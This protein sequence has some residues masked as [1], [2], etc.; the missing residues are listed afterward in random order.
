MSTLLLRFAAPL[1]AWGTDSKFEVRRTDRN[2]SKSGVI[3]LLGAALGIPRDG[4]F[5]ALRRLKMGVRVDR[6]GVLL[7]D[8][9]TAHA[10]EGKAS[11]ITHRYYLSDAI[12]LVGLEGD[13]KELQEIGE[14]LH[15]P[16]H[17]LYLG[18]RSCPPTLPIVLGL[19]DSGLREALLEERCLAEAENKSRGT[20][21]LLESDSISDGAFCRDVPLSYGPE[22]RSY[23]IRRVQE[24]IVFGEAAPAAAGQHDPMEE[25]EKETQDVSEQN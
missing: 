13:E 9:H 12:F 11:Y 6:E 21:L 22:R 3:G 8:Y 14:A 16:A 1:Q 25:L 15:H 4:D 17:P 19:R 7:R 24:T 23:G 20:R 2:P 18:R 10:P 5:S